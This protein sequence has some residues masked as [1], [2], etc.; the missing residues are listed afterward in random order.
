VADR[1]LDGGNVS[2]GVGCTRSF[3][4]EVAT[5]GSPAALVGARRS[6]DSRKAYGNVG[7][8]ECSDWCRLWIL[9]LVS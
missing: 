3:G 9:A 6:D 1:A 7:G 8:E 4:E 2:G 5:L